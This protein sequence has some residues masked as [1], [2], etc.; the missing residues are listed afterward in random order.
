MEEWKPVVGFEGLYEVSNLGQIRSL[1][2]LVNHP[3]GTTALR[4]GQLLKQTVNRYGYPCCTPSKN[5]KKVKLTMHRIVAD[6][7]LGANTCNLDIN[8]IDG[9][10]LNCAVSNLEYC[11]RR[12]NIQHAIKMGL[13]ILQRPPI[14]RGEEHGHSKLSQKDVEDIRKIGATIPSR[15]LASKYGVSKT[16][17]LNIL[18]NKIWKL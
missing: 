12:E 8:H 5:G 1:D 18:K 14:K 16:N 10:K 9:N 11:T 2:R 17:I 7:F 4:K 15:K 3:H 13:F 6:A